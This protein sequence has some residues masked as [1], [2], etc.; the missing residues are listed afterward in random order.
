M[1][2]KLKL[3]LYQFI[4]P[5]LIVIVFLLMGVVVFNQFTKNKIEAEADKHIETQFSTLD[6]LYEDSKKWNEVS[7]DNN[8]FLPFGALIF[9]EKNKMIMPDEDYNNPKAIEKVKDIKEYFLNTDEDFHKTKTIIIGDKVYR[10]EQR[11]YYGRYEGFIAFH[12]RQKYNSEKLAILAY[13]DMTNLIH[14][15][16]SINIIFLIVIGCSGALILIALFGISKKIE[17]SFNKLKKFILKVGRRESIEEFD[18]MEIVE[19]DEVFCTVKVMSDMIARSE[20]SQKIFFQNASHELKTPLM[21]IQGYS[22]AIK[23]GVMDTNTSIDIILKETD[24]MSKLIEEILLISK[25]ESYELKKE[26]FNLKEMIYQSAWSLKPYLD[27]RNIDMKFYFDDDIRLLTGDEENLQKA[28][29][30]II[31][32]AGRYA[33][34]LVEIH[35]SSEDDFIKIEISDDGEGVAEE[36][37]PYIFDR[38][39]KGK[40]GNFGIGLSLSKEIIEKHNGSIMVYN[41]N[42]ANFVIK[43]S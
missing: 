2:L 16:D 21:S 25:M 37:L 26:P 3:K 33:N 10:L 27:E 34:S 8:F 35:V 40:G 17:T 30:N 15:I 36:D 11:D 43:I 20:H 1:K 28:I 24:R 14:F 9:N 13:C 39:Y 42:G 4:L 18:N 6:L 22:E 7:Q 5:T 38:F 31:S 23:E 29:T 19:F 12:T 41:D 32:N